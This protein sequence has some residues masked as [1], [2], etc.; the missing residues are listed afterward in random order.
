MG[1]HVYRW[2]VFSVSL[3]C[4]Y[5]TKCVCL[6]QADIIILLRYSLFSPWYS[7]NI[8][9]VVSSNNHSLNLSRSCR[10]R[11]H[12]VAEFTTT[13]AMSGHHKKS[14]E[15]ESCWWWGVL[16]TILCDRV[17]HWLATGWWFS[18][19]TTFPPAIQLTATIKKWNVIGS[20]IKHHTS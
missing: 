2:T 4:K 8:A 3:Q 5:S 20:G 11:D 7:Q 9:E 16:D 13:Y 14:C 18:V 19:D 12:M 1:R 10:G 6:V 15:F 17:Y